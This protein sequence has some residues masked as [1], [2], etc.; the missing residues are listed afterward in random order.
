[1]NVHF[2]NDTVTGGSY[3]EVQP[4]A[5]SHLH[6]VGYTE[7][8]LHAQVPPPVVYMGRTRSSVL[9]GPLCTDTEHIFSFLQRMHASDFVSTSTYRKLSAADVTLLEGILRSIDPG[10]HTMIEVSFDGAVTVHPVLPLMR[11]EK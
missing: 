3:E 8:D 2:I 6:R 10:P 7:S 1:M 11:G 4:K 5:R 9:L